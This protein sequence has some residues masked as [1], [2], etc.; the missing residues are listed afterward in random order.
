[1]AG[2]VYGETERENSGAVGFPAQHQEYGI[3]EIAS[4]DAGKPY[5]E[6]SLLEFAANQ[7][8]APVDRA[9]VVNF[10]LEALR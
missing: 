9:S 3:R 7:I 6:P 1:M 4:W 8:G 2:F 5:A 10:F